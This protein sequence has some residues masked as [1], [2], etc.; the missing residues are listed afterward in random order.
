MN[1]K[2]FID[3]YLDKIS[4]RFKIANK[5]LCFEIFAIAVILDKPFEEVYSQ[6]S[7]IVQGNNHTH[8]GEH[9]GGIDGV[10]MDEDNVL[11]VFQCK[12]S[13]TIGDNAIGKFMID[14]QNLFWQ[15]NARKLPLNVKIEA[16]LNELRDLTRQGITY[17]IQ[18]HFVFNGER[19]GQ[20]LNV[21][22]RS[23]QG[24]DELKIWDAE[25][26]YKRVEQLQFSG[27]QRK[28]LNF[29]FKAE[30]SN[31]ALNAGDPQTLVSFAKGNVRAVTF[32]LCAE[33]L[34]EL[35]DAERQ[36]NSGA[37]DHLFGQ[38]IRGFLGS[39]KANKAIEETL[40]SDE[41]AY[42]PFFNNGIT[43][44]AEKVLIPTGPQLGFYPIQTVNPVIV[45]GLQT[46]HVIYKIF[47]SNPEKLRGVEVLVRLYDTQDKELADRITEA[48]NT[49]S[50]I[51]FRDKI[52][53]RGFIKRL[54]DLFEGH[55]IG[56]IVKR[57]QSFQNKLSRELA[58][59]IESDT[60][61]KFWFASYFERPE[62]AKGRKAEILETIYD[63]ASK[64][65]GPLHEIFSDA[66]D[67]PV[68]PQMLKAY[69]LYRFIYQKKDEN[70]GVGG[71]EILQYADEMICYGMYKMIEA[72]GRLDQ[73][74]DDAYLGVVYDKVVGYLINITSTERA[75]MAQAGQDYYHNTY[76]KSAK[77]RYDLNRLADWRESNI[78]WHA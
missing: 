43:I 57:G 29:T 37:D 62:T 77:A 5:D 28:T 17:S 13:G 53:N 30:K 52:S 35:I 23:E 45:N 47:K 20:N 7:T 10:Y 39:V 22:S 61:F 27:R 24:V 21:A 48:T 4:A 42:F 12:S 26:L 54:I 56:L 9:D 55:G 40:L 58:A 49:Q 60:L 46:T 66:L 72:Q 1:R 51:N 25:D 75:S 69:A 31:I 67:S 3:G 64:D 70:S 15:D 34:C 38:N 16:R 50:A 76:F 2:L 8:S 78:S 19:S 6:Y 65:A 59:T 36:Q 11:H 44:I 71:Q 74:W 63:A 18:L 14:Y 32:R 33:S 41:A 73:Q 68:Y